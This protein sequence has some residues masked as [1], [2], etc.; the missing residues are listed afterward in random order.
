MRLNQKWNAVAVLGLLIWVWAL[1]AL[2]QEAGQGKQKI[3]FVN[4]DTIESQWLEY[5]VLKS[6]LDKLFKI[7]A[8]DI[9][10]LQS[11]LLKREESL[12]D[13]RAQGFI[14][15]T[16]YNN[17][18]SQLFAEGKRVAVYAQ[19]RAQIIQRKVD[20]RMDRATKIV[21]EAINQ[22]GQEEG[23]DLIVNDVKMLAV[24]PEMDISHKVAKVLNSKDSGL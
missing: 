21:Q 4:V 6:D 20:K 8:K 11:D 13:S 1:P 22:I 9:Q 10:D 18:R 7:D 17:R 24:D 3:G 5:Q 15:E 2:A 23:F 19:M 12:R 16:S 14:D